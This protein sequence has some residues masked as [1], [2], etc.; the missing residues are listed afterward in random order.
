MDRWQAITVHQAV[1]AGATLHQITLALGEAP[2]A[3]VARWRTWS[4]GQRALA[5]TSVDPTEHDQ[6][7]ANLTDQLARSPRRTDP[8]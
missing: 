3:V 8:P 4:T 7:A 5:L 2:A 6:V 1:L